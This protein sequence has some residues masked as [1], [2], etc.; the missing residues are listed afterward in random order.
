MSYDHWKTTLPE[1]RDG[2]THD[3]EPRR[4]KPND[5]CDRCGARA[6]GSFPGVVLCREHFYE[7]QRAVIARMATAR[8]VGAA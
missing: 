5:H 3:R 1:D 6:Y 7:E 4:E 2:A 8:K